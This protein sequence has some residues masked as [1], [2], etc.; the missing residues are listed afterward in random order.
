MKTMIG[1]TST[2]N[3]VEQML[4]PTQNQL[5][6]LSARLIL[7]HRMSRGPRAMRTLF[8]LSSTS[9]LLYQWPSRPRHLIHFPLL[10]HHNMMP[11]LKHTFRQR[12]LRLRPCCQSLQS[13][14]LLGLLCRQRYQRNLLHLRILFRCPNAVLL[15]CRTMQRKQH[16]STILRSYLLRHLLKQEAGGGDEA[17]RPGGGCITTRR[18]RRDRLR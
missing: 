17:Q 9:K 16:L 2:I 5:L 13:G 11:P 3:I 12:R 4:L 18:W 1:E 8:S 14:R 6:K 10:S 15:R 7:C